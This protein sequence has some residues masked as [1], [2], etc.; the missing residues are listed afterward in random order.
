MSAVVYINQTMITP[1]YK[2]KST[3]NCHNLNAYKQ[4]DNLCLLK[5]K[6]ERQHRKTP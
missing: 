2:Y 4:R 1:L 6:R 3:V 5:K